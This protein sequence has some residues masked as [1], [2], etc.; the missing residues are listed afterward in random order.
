MAATSDCGASG[1]VGVV[2]KLNRPAST[3]SPSR[4]ESSLKRRRRLSSLSPEVFHRTSGTN[5]APFF[6]GNPPKR[7]R[8]KSMS[9]SP[10]AVAGGGGDVGQLTSSQKCPLSPL[11]SLAMLAISFIR[12]SFH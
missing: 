8:T 6:P 5:M 7:A 1:E 4:Q 3:G 11:P 10:A 12:S 9:S 2:G